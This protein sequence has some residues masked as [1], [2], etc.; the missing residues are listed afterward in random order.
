MNKKVIRHWY[1]VNSNAISCYLSRVI[2]NWGY[3]VQWNPSEDSESYYI[4]VNLGTVEEPKALH[5]RISDHSVSPGRKWIF[6]DTDL[7]CSYERM[8]ATS[9][10]KFLTKLS[11]ELDKPMPP[12]LEKVK[13]GTEPYKK[14]RIKMQQR[15]KKGNR[16]HSKDRLYV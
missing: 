6:F 9:Y 8:G 15:A 11:G 16:F 1:L 7:Y 3:H 2:I 14:Y 5:I 13:T 10:I 4:N 12:G